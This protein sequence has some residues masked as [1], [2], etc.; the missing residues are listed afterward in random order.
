MTKTVSRRDFLVGSGVL[1][2]AVALAGLSG[3]SPNSTGSASHNLS[4][5]S[6]EEG[7]SSEASKGPSRLLAVDESDVARTEECDVVVCGSGSAGT[8]AAIR[9]AELGAR[10]IWLEKTNLKGGTS[11]V[12]EGTLAYNTKEQVEA[13]VV[14][15]PQEEFVTY[16]KWHNWGAYG[17]GVRSFLDNSGQAIDWAIE[18]GAMMAT[19]GYGALHSCFDEDGNWVNNGEGMLKPLW[20]FGDTLENLDFRL[21]TPAVNVIVEDGVVKGVY[22]QSGDDI[23]R[24]NAKAT[25]LAT[26]GFGKNPEMCAERLRV[27][28]ERVVFLGFDGQDGDGINMALE[29]GAAPQAPSSVMYGLSKACGESWSSMLSIFTQWPPS[30]RYPLELGKFLPMVNQNGERFYNETLGEDADTARLNVAIASQPKVFTLFNEDHV[31]AYEGE[32]NL[33]N[34][35]AFMGVGSGELRSAVE[36][37]DFVWSAD[38]IED[39]AGQIGVDATVLA[40]TVSDWNSCATG[41][42]THDAFGADP[43]QMTVL[44]NGP[45]YAVQVEA[46]AYSTCGGIRGNY[47][48]RAVDADDKPIPGLF[49]CGIDNGSMQYNDYPYGLHGGS[50]QG[51]ACTTGYVA[52]NA[53]CKDLGLA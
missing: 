41:G 51:A 5:T 37:S 38:T 34:F 40:S 27:P 29:A 1:G 35:V 21:E 8:Y 7:I 33:N 4:A 17:P 2:S 45:F 36:N 13:G 31:K 3:C 48:A 28:S 11:T 19:S 49:V 24:I 50:G 23:I 43:A 52:A 44:E 22:A 53:A 30:Y 15:E 9:S 47:E 16:M 20:A 10:V 39:L 32:E 26:G 14:F 25:I 6:S 42:D 18:H 12:K 46:C